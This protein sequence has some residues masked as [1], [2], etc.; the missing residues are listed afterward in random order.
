MHL[1]ISIS[2]YLYFLFT[3]HFWQQIIVFVYGLFALGITISGFRATNQ[4]RKAYEETPFSGILFSAFVQ[5]DKLVF[6]PFWV[7]VSFITLIL[8]DWLLFLLFFSVFW[9]VRSIGETIYWF[10][11]QFSPRPGNDPEKFFFYR[12]VHNDSVWFILQIWWQC[13]T[14]ITI[15]STIYLSHLWL[16]TL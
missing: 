15:I 11:Q 3:M 9:L 13:L 10:L 5:A 6:G 8:N 1:Y 7:M 14:V 12:Y 4:K 16:K 2:L